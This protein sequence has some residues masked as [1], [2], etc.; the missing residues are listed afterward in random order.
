MISGLVTEV[1]QIC[2]IEEG[3]GSVLAGEAIGMAVKVNGW[4][5]RGLG[6]LLAAALL[7]GHELLT[8]P[9]AGA[10]LWSNRWFLIFQV[11]LELAL[12][13]WLVSGVFKR[14]AW[15]A[16]LGCFGVFCAVTLYKGLAGFGSCGC[17]G[18]VHV[19]PW[20]TL[21]AVDLP[22]AALLGVFR[23]SMDWR[24]VWRL[25]HWLEP[26]PHS[27]VP[28]VVFLLGLSA[29]GGTSPVLIL[30]EPPAVT[31]EYEILEPETWVGKELPILEHIDIG[32]QLKEGNWLV[33]LY[34][35]DCP[36]CAEALPQIEAMARE[37]E[38]NEEF[39]RFALVEVPPYGD[40]AIGNYINVKLGKLNAGKEWFITT[41]AVAL[42]ENGQV[43]SAWEG[44]APD[45]EEVIRNI[46]K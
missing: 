10:D 4:V 18:R 39:L 22:A 14:A 25:G 7:K 12:G 28:G 26:V 23:P 5:L 40:G 1:W 15:L 30:R 37:L 45:M 35:H 13:I 21:F 43:A 6:M 27:G 36:D 46:Y 34:H 16:A 20:V 3:R 41:P 9:M 19:S 31:S 2:G 33:V 29:V 8:V 44:K 32:E 17:F 11:E 38:G 24:R 42:L